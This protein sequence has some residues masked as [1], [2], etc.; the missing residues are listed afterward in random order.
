MGLEW[1]TTKRFENALRSAVCTLALLFINE[2]T[3]CIGLNKDFFAN[4]CTTRTLFFY[5]NVCMNE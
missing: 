3:F 4:A 5:V 2:Q 1:V